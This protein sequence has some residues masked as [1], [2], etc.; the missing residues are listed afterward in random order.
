M[1]V[2]PSEATLWQSVLTAKIAGWNKKNGSKM[3]ML[4]RTHAHPYGWG[5]TVPTLALCNKYIGGDFHFG[6]SLKK[7]LHFRKNVNLTKLIEWRWHLD[8]AR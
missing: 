8:L 2:T 7:N 3:Q 4:R 1:L 5:Q 6:N